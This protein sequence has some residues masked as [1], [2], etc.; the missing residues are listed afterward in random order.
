MSRAV[1]VLAMTTGIPASVWAE[2][3]PRTLATAFEVFAE[4]MEDEDDEPSSA[5]SSDA[6]RRS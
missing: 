6:A 4:R 1:V 2:E 3:D 5:P